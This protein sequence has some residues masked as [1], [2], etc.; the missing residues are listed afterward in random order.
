LLVVLR[1][2]IY[3]RFVGKVGLIIV[4]RRMFGNCVS[5]AA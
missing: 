4:T 2:Y 5:S 1:A 3:V